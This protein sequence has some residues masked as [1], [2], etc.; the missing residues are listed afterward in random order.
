M[1]IIMEGKPR[2][3]TM[4]AQITCRYCE[5]VFQFRRSEG[6]Y[7]GDDSEGDYVSV[8]CPCCLGYN[9]VSLRCFNIAPEKEKP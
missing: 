3:E 8:R 6:T 4:L 5:A 2:G 9:H 7:C 1:Q